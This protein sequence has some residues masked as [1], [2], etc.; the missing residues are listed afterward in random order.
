MLTRR[1]Q[2]LSKPTRF[3]RLGRLAGVFALVAGL[4]GLNAVVADAAPDSADGLTSYVDLA[5]SSFLAIAGPSEYVDAF[6]AVAADNDNEDEDNEEAEEFEEDGLLPS[7]QAE[8]RA[9]GLYDKAE[10]REEDHDN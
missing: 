9:Q 10:A 4:Y 3:A 5:E 6:N 7:G 1:Q 8:Q 2:C